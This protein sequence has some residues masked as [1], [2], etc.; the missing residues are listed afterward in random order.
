MSFVPKWQTGDT[1]ILLMDEVDHQ[2]DL[3]GCQD[4]G[5]VVLVSYLPIHHADS[6]DGL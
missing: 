5:H 6:T 1:S 4:C 3:P 2:Y